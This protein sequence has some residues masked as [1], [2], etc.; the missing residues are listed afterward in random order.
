MTAVSHAIRVLIC[1]LFGH[2][3]RVN[4][5][6]TRPVMPAICTRCMREGST[7]ECGWYP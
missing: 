4:L 3:W 6:M 7:E 2:R 5:R 1:R